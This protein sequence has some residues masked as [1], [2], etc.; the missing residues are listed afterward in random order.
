MSFDLT[1]P[2]IL[3]VVGLAIAFVIYN[4]MSRYDAG[5]EKVRGIADQIHLGAMVFLHREYKMLAM[6][7]GVL[8]VLILVSPLGVNT[9]ISFAVGAICSATAGYLGM[10]SATRANVRTTVAAHNN[11]QA[12]ALT[13][14]FYGGSVMG[15]LVAS[16]GL[17]GLGGL[18]YYFGGDSQ[19][20][21][22]IHG[23]GMGASV[24]ALFSRVGGGIFTNIAYVCSDLVG[25]IEAGIPEEEDQ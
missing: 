12:E 18:Y 25:K 7:G 20:A 19:T 5:G 24:V 13:V 23:F 22:S 1:L 9:G 4:I 2:P 16:L 21:H 11:G 8:L 17:I 6:F 3:G 15:L 14:A 10:F